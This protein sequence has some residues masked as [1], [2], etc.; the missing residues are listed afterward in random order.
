MPD[1]QVDD[2]RRWHVDGRGWRDIGYHFVVERVNGEF[3][4][5]AGRPLY[6]AGAHTRGRNTTH[7][8]VAL[9][10]DFSEAALPQGQAACAARLIAGLCSVTG[11]TADD[12]SFHRDH[13]STQCPGDGV[14]TSNLV[15]MVADLL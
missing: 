2:I 4:A 13:A 5:I 12:V 9:V 6:M 1:I 14:V 15:E 7:I 10:G 8:G 11:L 3:F